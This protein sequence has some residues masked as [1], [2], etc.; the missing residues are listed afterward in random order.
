VSL[1]LGAVVTNTSFTGFTCISHKLKAITL[2]KGLQALN[3]QKQPNMDD[4]TYKCNLCGRDDFRSQRTLTSHKLDKKGCASN[5]KARFGS[6]A[7]TEIAAA[8]LPVD[9]VFNPQKCAAGDINGMKYAHWSDGL[10][11]KRA[12]FMTAPDEEFV[13]SYLAKAQKQLN[14][15][16][17]NFDTG[18]FVGAYDSENEVD[19]SGAGQS[20]ARQEVMLDDFKNYAQRAN[21]FIPLDSN[22]M[23]T[24]ITLLQLLRRT[25]ASLDTYED[26]MRWHL[27]SQNL[28]HPRDSLAKSPHFVSRKKVY[29]YLRKRYNRDTGFGIKTQLVLPG[30]KSRA[31]MVTNDA[32][33]VIQQLLID[34]RVQPNDYLFNDKNDPFA[35]PPADL[36]YIADLNTGKSYIETWKKLI[37]KPGKQI[38]CPLLLYIDGAATG[39]FVDLPITAVKIALGIH[40]RVAREKPYLWGTLG[41][42]PEPTKVKSGGMRQLVNS[43]HHDG[44]IPY[45]EML[46]NEGRIRMNEAKRQAKK[47]QT[48]LVNKTD[49]LQKCQDLHAMLDHILEGLVKIQKEGLTWDLIY[50]GRSF[51]GV[52]FV[53]FVPFIRCDTDEAD[54][55][56]GSYTNRTANVAQLCRYCMCP[57]AE[58][59]NIRA[60]YRK[61]TPK[62]IAKLV[63]RQD[64]EGLRKLSQ[65]NLHNAFHKVRFGMHTDQGVHGACPLEMLHAILLG[66]F[67]MIR[68]FFFWKV[69]VDSMSAKTL[70]ILASEYGRLL[71][72]QSDRDM[73]K[74]KFSGGI[75]R[76]KLMAKEYTGILLVLLITIKSPQGQHIMARRRPYF[77]NPQNIT[78][79]IMLIETSL[80]WI[81]W[82]QSPEMPLK[83]VERC[84]KKF[85]TIMYL[86][87]RITP[88]IEGMGLKTTKFHCILHMPEDML[89]YGVPME[90]DTRFNEM[91]HKPS[92]AA[93]ALTQKDKSKFEEQ[94]HKRMEEVHLLELAEEEMEGRGIQY[95][96]RGHDFE[97]PRTPV[98]PNKTG[99]RHFVASTHPNSG[100]NFMYDPADKTHQLGNAHVE[101]DLIDFLVDLQDRVNMDIPQ[102]KLFTLHRRNGIIFRGS[103]CFRG[104]VWRDWVVVDWGSSFEKLPSRIWGFVDLSALRKNSRI[105]IGGMY[106]LQPG[107]YAVVESS[108]RAENA[109]N[110]ELIT[111]IELEVGGFAAGGYVSQL[112]FFLAPVEAFVAPTVV[113]PNIGGKN[114]SY[115]WLKP[116]HVWG[117]CFR[118]WL[119]EPYHMEDLSDSEADTAEEESDF[120]V[121]SADQEDEE[122]DSDGEEDSVAEL[123]VE[124]EGY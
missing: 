107:V 96:Y 74:T 114:N 42:L 77:R 31:N 26:T 112:K 40:T 109:N 61:K 52:E 35:P 12:K 98:K 105:N 100:R 87:K 34:P 70:N 111:E 64:E 29:D 28:L 91:H 118:R 80:Q 106:N 81:E 56:C 14:Y 23:V 101:L 120:S 67:P 25:K 11:P 121:A 38:L 85:Q 30:S 48:P 15:T 39:Q 19:V 17:I 4:P 68:D 84:P 73:P 108:Q 72:R 122:A 89:A 83:D 99:G 45:F 69:G 103:A 13:N 71:S 10:G 1:V 113:V 110:T 65:R 2:K 20:C 76:G 78:N 24:A 66:H 59:D 9:M 16:Q 88:K 21:G 49:A 50:N 95:Y 90:V 5:L 79:W 93:A 6:V 8:F 32:L 44:T 115:M 86:L 63:E 60:K 41:Y 119:H 46:D 27:V 55:L 58:S 36:D 18:D 22:K 92:K 51:R 116:R 104:S 3:L 47:G 82:L 7:E 62:I 94:V 37:T 57:T 53:F 43:G 124:I 54:K 75:R 117:E 97:P 33:K 123:D 102:V